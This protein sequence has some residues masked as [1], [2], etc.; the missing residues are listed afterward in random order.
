MNVTEIKAIVLTSSVNPGVSTHLLNIVSAE[1]RMKQTLDS[2]TRWRNSVPVAIPIL[3]GDNS[4]GF[5]QL[6]TNVKHAHLENVYVIEVHPISDSQF[7]IGG[8]GLSE[9]NT[10]LTILEYSKLNKA[11]HILKSNARYYV[12]NWKSMVEG[13][14]SKTRLAV[15]PGGSLRYVETGFYVS[16]VDTLVNGLPNIMP[17]ID[18]KNGIFVEHL[19]PTLV[20]GHLNQVDL[21]QFPPAIRGVRGHTG[22]KEDWKSEAFSI[23]IIVSVRNRIKKVIK[24]FL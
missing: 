15:W 23:F 13:L 19:Y 2:L 12:Y 20:D 17:R 11:D 1:I 9:C 14:P 4:A 22:R 10:I 6:V 24:K 16:Q 18:E 21:F 3:I 7:S 5:S 8:A